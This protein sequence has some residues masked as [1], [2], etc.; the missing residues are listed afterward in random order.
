MTA[1]TA[2]ARFTKRYQDPTACH[3]ALANYHWL[4]SLGEPLRLPRLLSV[5]LRHHQFE[6]IRGRV[7]TPDD[8]VVLAR[9]LGDV[10]G[11][12]Y[13]KALHPARLDTP[14]STDNG[15][16]LPD[17]LTPRLAVLHQRLHSGA[18]L[19]PRLDVAHATALLRRTATAP[20]A[21]YK[22]ANPRN[23][24]ITP[25][26][27]ITLDFDDLTLAPFGYDLAKLI[28]TLAMTYGHISCSEIERALTAYNEGANDHRPRLGRVTWPDLM[29]W[30][31][32]HHILTSAYL[33]QGSYHHSWHTLRPK[34]LV[35][36]SD[37]EATSSLL[38]E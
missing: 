18:V 35:A 26:G 9:H 15:H 1:R 38:A 6:L 8:L 14:Y 31:E 13:V 34:A 7:V 4:A 28:V 27:P 33:G 30:T 25:D 10:H 23:F 21:L 16:H 3:T 22:D 2:K 11:T 12:A 19:E 29:T 20:A 36:V 32:V 37:R 24:L 17:F 5:G